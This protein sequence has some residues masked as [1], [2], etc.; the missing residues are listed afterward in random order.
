MENRREREER[1]KRKERKGGEREKKKRTST[2][3]S[4]AF[5]NVKPM[6]DC[7]KNRF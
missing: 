1:E 3:Q 5:E 6:N 7:A 4:R 2:V